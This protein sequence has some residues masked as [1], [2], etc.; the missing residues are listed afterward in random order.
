MGRLSKH[1]LARKLAKYMM[2]GSDAEDE[3]AW[4]YETYMT[5]YDVAESLLM[6]GEDIEPSDYSDK[7]PIECPKCATC[8][9]YRNDTELFEGRYVCSLIDE[10]FT[11]HSGGYFIPPSDF[12][13]TK[14]A[15][16]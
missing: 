7:P 9:F 5:A 6:A 16:K 4:L 8:R 1:E 3:L 15:S 14:H 2:Q 12:G 13:C 11:Q 10:T